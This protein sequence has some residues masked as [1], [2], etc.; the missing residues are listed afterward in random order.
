MVSHFRHTT[1]REPHGRKR[2]SEPEGDAPCFFQ[3]ILA[4][5]SPRKL[6]AQGSQSAGLRSD[7]ERSR[8]SRAVE[9][10][11]IERPHPPLARRL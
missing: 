5:P 4:V 3:L 7:K 2:Q 10:E 9:V 1:G 6:W 8:R 11:K